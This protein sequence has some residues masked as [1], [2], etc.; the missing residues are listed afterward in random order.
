VTIEGIANHAGTTPMDRRR[1]ALL[2]AAELTLAVNRIA[3]TTPGRQ[4][5]T[6]GRIRAEPG[7][8]NVIP[9]RVTMS[10]EIRDLAAEKMQ[11]V[12]RTI[13]AEAQRIAEARQTPIGF[14]EIDVALAPAP[15]DE[16]VRRIIAES[17]RSLGLT[18]QSMPSGAGHDAQDMS[19]IAPIG[20]I[21]VPSKGGISHSPKE[22]T[23]PADMANGVNV[24]LRTILAIDQGGLD[25]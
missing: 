25:R 11:Q 12:F 20:M 1:D 2:S 4:V 23:S 18:V 22:Y 7:A 6:V 19:H 10:L 8:P 14:A 9:G 3:T 17:A 21:F 16:R 13:A 24:L 5:A 15:T